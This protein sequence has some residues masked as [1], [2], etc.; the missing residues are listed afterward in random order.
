MYIHLSISMD[1]HIEAK[2]FFPLN[3]SHNNYYPE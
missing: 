3:D 1:V 2:D